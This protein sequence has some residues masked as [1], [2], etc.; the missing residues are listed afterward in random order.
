MT[1]DDYDWDDAQGGEA[2]EETGDG[3]K[4]PGEEADSTEKPQ[5]GTMT[6]VGTDE[7]TDEPTT[8]PLEALY[9]DGDEDLDEIAEA[10]AEQRAKVTAQIK[11]LREIE[12]GLHQR[13]DAI[14][15][16]GK[17]D[18]VWRDKIDQLIKEA[19]YGAVREELREIGPSLE[20]DDDEKQALAEAFGGAIEDV[21][22]EVELIRSR[23]LDLTPAGWE[24]EH[25]VSFLYGEHS[26]KLTKRGLRAAFD[27]IDDVDRTGTDDDVLA[28]YV[29]WQAGDGLTVDD[30]ERILE[31]IR[32][33][34][35]D[36]PGGVGVAVDAEAG[37]AGE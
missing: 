37:E 26:G 13:A 29:A 4:K 27:V 21:T 7:N 9:V 33:A 34:A 28:R 1:G 2:D 19:D 6:D 23:L 22:A 35:E 5:D 24:R 32:E 31:A 3:E 16:A 36:A 11:K 25:L 15:A 10:A 20:F 30:A 12:E 14:V 18:V 17:G 8:S